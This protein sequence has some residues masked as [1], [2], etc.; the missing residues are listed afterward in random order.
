MDTG[1]WIVATVM[2]FMGFGLVALLMLA[3]AK[4]FV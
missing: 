4:I 3:V 1:E 2:I